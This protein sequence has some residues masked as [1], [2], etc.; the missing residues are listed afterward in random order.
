MKQTSSNAT[1]LSLHPSKPPSLENITSIT[2]QSRAS[3]SEVDSSERKSRG[4]GGG[5][6]QKR[7]SNFSDRVTPSSPSTPSSRMASKKTS[8]ESLFSNYNLDPTVASGVGLNN[9]QHIS[10]GGNGGVAEDPP[11][12]MEELLKLKERRQQRLEQLRRL[13]HTTGLANSAASNSSVGSTYQLQQHQQK[14]SELFGVPQARGS[15][16]QPKQN[17]F[18]GIGSRRGALAKSMN[19]QPKRASSVNQCPSPLTRRSS[20]PLEMSSTKER[21]PSAPSYPTTEKRPPSSSNPVSKSR[22]TS[23]SS[24]RTE[25]RPRKQSPHPVHILNGMAP[26]SAPT[27]TVISEDRRYHP[28]VEDTGEDQHD[29]LMFCQPILTKEEE[30]LLNEPSSTAIQPHPSSPEPNSYTIP[31]LPTLDVD[32]MIDYGESAEELKSLIEA[33]H[34]EFQNLRRAKTL[35]EARAEKLQTDFSIQQQ[36]VE[37][38]LL[39]LSDEN[40]RLKVEVEEHQL[41]LEQVSKRCSM[42]E[43][44]NELLKREMSK[45]QCSGKDGS[46]DRSSLTSRRKSSQGYPLLD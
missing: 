4:G 43:R 8:S 39:M 18:I 44:E 36:E 12:H 29:K 25:S 34:I 9:D 15:P 13:K 23:R 28:K 5:L 30:D 40:E 41:Q 38:Q 22:P 31:P 7:S 3:A 26:K 37:A 45:E 33:M 14:A 35:A 32:T 19:A 24:S 11:D 17:T 42:V 46:W 1:N 2:W 27:T 21:T 6:L 20:A 16:K 10:S